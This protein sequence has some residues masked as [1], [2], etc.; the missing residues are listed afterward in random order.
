M[1]RYECSEKT[2]NVHKS[3]YDFLVEQERK[4]MVRNTE[5]LHMLENIDSDGMTAT[6]TE[7]LE[8][9]K[10]SVIMAM[11]TRQGRW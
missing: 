4:R 8:L 6:R 2:A 1:V 5:L 9:L 3:K 10:V 7:R 11:R